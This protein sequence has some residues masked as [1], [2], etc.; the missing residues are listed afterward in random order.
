MNTEIVVAYYNSLA[1]SVI[2]SAFSKETTK[3]IVY[4][5]S[6][7]KQEPSNGFI[8]IIQNIYSSIFGD[9]STSNR[10]NTTIWGSKSFQE[11]QTDFPNLERIPR[12]NRGRE[13]ETYLSHIIDR[14]DSLAEYTI[15]IQDDFD[16]HIPR[17]DHFVYNTNIMIQHNQAFY[18]YPCSWKKGMNP[19]IRTIE[20]GIIDLETFPSPDAIL[21]TA[22]RFQIALPIIYQTDV[23][24]F[25]IVSR[26]RIRARPV[27]F[28]RELREWLLSDEAN[29]FVLEHIWQLIFTSF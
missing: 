26:D 24:A 10:S 20:N 9:N 23:C 21:Q 2:L 8:K 28:Y 14:Y 22:L 5:K 6:E 3:I 16:N 18:A 15:F 29:G 7:P 19:F 1:F 11:I 25:F 17:N 13:G 27:T 4:D 12:E